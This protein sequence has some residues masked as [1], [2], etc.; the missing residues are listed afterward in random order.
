MKIAYSFP[1][2]LVLLNLFSTL[3]AQEIRLNDQWKFSFGDDPA[4][5]SVTFDDSSWKSISSA[6]SWENQGFGNV[7]G[8]AWYRRRVE[9][10]ASLRSQ[11]RKYGGMTIN[12]DNVDDA[13]E[14]YFNGTRIGGSGAFPPNYQSR[15]GEKRKYNIPLN[16]INL[17]KENIIAVRV[18]DGGGGGGILSATTVLRPMV[19]TDWVEYSYTFPGK[20]WILSQGD[21]QH[22][23]LS[24]KNTRTEKLRFNV[25]F[26]LRTDKHKL[27][28]SL[29][30][31][32][33]LNPGK[34]IT[35]AIPMKLAAPGFYRCTM[36]FQDNG[37][38][39]APQKFNI[40]YEP[41][42]INS[43]LDAKPD[44]DA[45]WQQ[46]LS[47]LAKA[48][49]QYK[50]TLLPEHSGGSKNIYHV[51]MLSYMNVKIEGYYAVPKG[52]GKFPAI[53]NYMGYGSDARIPNP[54]HDPG[55][56]EFVLSVRGQGIQKPNNVYGEWN[57]WGLAA[58]ETY[59]YR[60]AFLDLVRAI[61][62]LSSRPEI[63]AEKIVA[64]G[65]SQGGAFALAAA[66]LDKRIKAI[67]PTI[68]FLSDYRHYFQ[69]VPWPR[70]NFE[71]YLASHPDATWG[72]IYDVLTYFDV[73]NL[74]P[75]ITC[76]VFMAV[77]LQDEI[78]P[79]YT[80]FAAYNQIKSEKQVRIYH[81]H[82]HNTPEEWRNIRLKFFRERLGITD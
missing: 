15:Y 45:F 54:G 40:G 20:D 32:I 9:I 42:K 34:W 25:L 23:L 26:V 47:D 51:E 2:L 52:S 73:K 44:F 65:A 56:A 50:L 74:A 41:F 76:P 31:P 66:A 80:N 59:Y 67:A 60:G 39:G 68:P 28:D 17:G 13:D 81:D 78:C 49:P 8:F 36:Y 16:I 4:R 82:A 72:K 18:Y 61:D 69:I 14:V 5:A 11:V 53:A 7:D 21:P 48:E 70:T 22:M 75:R 57:T 46:S 24:L 19:A 10:P 62:F 77:G 71:R 63:D 79:P 64:D 29:V 37:T 27:I 43:S 3:N 12:I 55:F 33:N 58:K 38:T 35:T 6:G 30:V 1:V